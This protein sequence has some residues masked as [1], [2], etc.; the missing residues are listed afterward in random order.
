LTDIETSLV[1][2][3]MGLSG[4]KTCSI[5]TLEILNKTDNIFIEKYTN[6]IS[7]QV[8]S[9]FK[10]I[11]SKFTHL[12]R[13]DLEEN[14]E[15][16]LESI[17]GKTV[18]LLVPGDPFIA[19]TH[20]SLRLLATKKGINCKIVHNTSIISAASSISGLLSYR[21]GRTVTCPFPWNKS[22]FPYE[23]VRSNKKINAHTLVLLDINERKNQFLCV[24]KAI[25]YFLDLEAKKLESVFLDSTLVV[26]LARIGYEDNYIAA[27]SSKSMKKLPWHEY[28]PPQTL[29]ICAD[30]LHFAETE[31]LETLWNVEISSE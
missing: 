6:F 15:E 7:G 22:E 31:A 11:E 16:F 3:G 20:N 18:A 5:E 9:A 2:I 29:I 13:S 19:T 28:G 27:G 21:F 12:S 26:G 17:T 4:L 25:D 8:P 10:E 23:I 24:D 30:D 14:D 1:F